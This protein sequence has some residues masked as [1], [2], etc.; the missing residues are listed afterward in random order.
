MDKLAK[1]LQI[2]LVKLHYD[3][4]SVS[5]QMRHYLE[6]LTHLLTVEDEETLLHY[7][8]ILGHE[9][10]SLDELAKER[11]LSPETMMALIDDSLHKIAIT[12]EWQMMKT[13]TI[14]K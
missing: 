9:Q 10:L 1:E 6:H 8:G 2:F 12:P 13:L 3:P 5:H 14:E 7:F 11:G 4:S